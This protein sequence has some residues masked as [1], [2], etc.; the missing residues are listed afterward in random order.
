MNKNYTWKKTC[1]ISAAYVGL[2]DWKKKQQPTLKIWKSFQIKSYIWT[3]NKVKMRWL[4]INMGGY[5]YLMPNRDQTSLNC[6][7][8]INFVIYSQ[9]RIRLMRRLE[10]WKKY[11]LQNSYESLSTNIIFYYITK[12]FGYMLRTVSRL[13]LVRLNK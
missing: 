4:S 10:I 2:S 8:S 3:K 9:Q 12:I 5:A 11:I 1:F 13:S 6:D 7:I